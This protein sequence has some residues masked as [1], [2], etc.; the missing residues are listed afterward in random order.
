MAQNRLQVTEL[1]FD[2]IKT[3]LK[4]FLKQQTEFQDY[5]FEGSGLNVLMNLLAYN[6]HYNA[7][8]LNMVANESFLDTALLRD[9]VVSH[10]KTLGYTPYSKTAATAIIDM[11]INSGSAT[12]D[13]L[14]IPKGYI[15][16]SN[17]IDKR[18]YSF[19]VLNETSVTKSGTQY[20]FENLNIK[21]GQLIN[22][23]FTYDESSNPKALFTLPDEGIDTNTITLTV[24]PSASNTQIQVYNKVTDILDTDATSQVFFLQET[25]GGKFQ[26]YF[27]NDKIGKKLAD[28]SVLS[29]NYLV[30][31]GSVANKIDGFSMTAA[32]GGF[33][34]STISVV[35]IASGGSDRETVD[36]IKAA[37]PV[38]FA[39]QN[40]LVTKVDYESYI[41]KSYPSIDSLSVWGGEDEL[42]PIYGKILISLKPK[43]NY[44]I[45]EIEKTRIINEIIKPKAIVSVSAEIRDPEYLYLILN[46]S[47]KYDEKKTTLDENSLRTLIRNAI[48]AYKNTSLNKFN[49]IFALSKLQDEIDRV[50]QNSIIGSETIVRLQKRFQPEIG[51]TSNY[52][53]NFGVPLHRGTITNRLTSS[54][55]ATFDNSG[56][57][58]TAIIEEIPQSSTGISSIE[59]SN[60]GYNYETAPTITITGDGVGATAVAIIQNGRITQ[61]KMTNRGIDYSR[62]VVT[63][64]GGGGYNAAASAVI[65]TRVGTIRTIYFDA[66]ANRQIINP[67][68]GQIN[69]GTGVITINDL[70]VLS[71]S[72]ADGLIRLSLESESGIIESNK[73]TIIT[74]DETDLSSIFTQ[75]LKVNS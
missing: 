51:S 35:S 4:S 59:I 73:S 57:S 72:T 54:E 28:G 42:P 71:V 36:E 30:T 32:I 67:S 17:I 12:V 9:S 47:V 6:T 64:S 70:R 1:D 69:Y 14:T 19:V 8:Y 37:S 63:I 48:I 25:K 5:D 24:R 55:F 41:K 2:T 68:V 61:I 75:L 46:S 21:E 52:T 38:Q 11:T 10:A 66:D 39:T 15:F 29:V 74:I 27:G 3:N 34:T 56:V 60:A 31:N 20:V 53:I 26:I 62:A 45:T 16:N 44:F 13:T 65:D 18:S 40:R 43:E 49:S 50:N 33:S 7:Y 58:R 23:N 22:Y